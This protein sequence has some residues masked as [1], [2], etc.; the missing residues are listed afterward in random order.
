M[1]LKEDVLEMKD[2]LSGLKNQS[3][4]WEML[5]DFKQAHRRICIS[6]TIIVSIIL[7]L[8]ACTLA[9]LVYVLNDIEIEET[10]EMTITQENEDGYNNY[11][12]NNGEIINDKTNN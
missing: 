5:K 7:V 1:S 10:T 3:F 2:E 8:W 9:Y 6:F 11:I 12:G 4:A